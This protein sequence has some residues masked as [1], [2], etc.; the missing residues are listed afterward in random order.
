M[1]R[2]RPWYCSRLLW[3]GFPGLLF[4][5]W[6]WWDSGAYES[7]LWADD[8][9][10]TKMVT[11][12]VKRGRIELWGPS[13]ALANSFPA[14]WRLSASRDQLTQEEFPADLMPSLALRRKQFDLPVAFRR[15]EDEAFFGEN[16]AFEGWVASPGSKVPQPAL[17]SVR[18][19]IAWW[20]GVLAY[21]LLG[22]LT[23][24]GW[25]R[26]K[27]RLLRVSAPPT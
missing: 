5:L 22:S 25:Q 27:A 18:I 2:M 23:L 20:C 8:P 3:L 21:G 7:R 9:S 4:L 26:R 14:G 19:E 17:T 11:L 12:E 10:T 13:G 16:P 6:I 1:I 15:L 24:V